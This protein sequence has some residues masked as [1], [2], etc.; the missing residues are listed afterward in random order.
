MWQLVRHPET[1]W[2]RQGR[3]QGWRDIP[4]SQTGEQQCRQ[5]LADLSQLPTTELI[6]SSDLGRCLAVAEPLAASL[7]RQ[8]RVLPALREL[9]F[10]DW[11]GLTFAEIGQRYPA[12]QA[13]WLRDPGQ[14]AP[15][16]GETLRQ[17][18]TRVTA[19]LAPYLEREL[20]IV[21]H[22]GVIAT[23]MQSWGEQSFQLPATG[24][25]LTIQ[26]RRYGATS[27]DQENG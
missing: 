2:N 17:L 1:E 5:L 18:R 3:Y 19:A 15:P 14:T 27:A 4:L 22:G 26:P 8:L 13:A 23:V 10:G 9:N 12:A 16:Q 24:S 7:D 21:T 6:L 20:I 11:E 25:R